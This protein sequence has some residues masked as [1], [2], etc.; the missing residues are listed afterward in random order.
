M[1]AMGTLGLRLRSERESRGL[2]RV[3]VARATKVWIHHL[4]A[5]EHDDY[6]ALVGDETAASQLRTYAEYL[7]MDPD[8]VVAELEKHVKLF[9]LAQELLG[10]KP[11]VLEPFEQDDVVVGARC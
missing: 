7:G 2:G 4:A 10:R 9:T 6:D 1:G 8:P 11:E 3:D 5:L